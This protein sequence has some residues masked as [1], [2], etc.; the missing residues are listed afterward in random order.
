MMLRYPKLAISYDL[1][2]WS[3]QLFMTRNNA[4]L[5]RSDLVRSFL[6]NDFGVDIEV[7]VYN[8]TSPYMG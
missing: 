6:D 7:S 1:E 8:N 2:S 5:M 4:I 3:P